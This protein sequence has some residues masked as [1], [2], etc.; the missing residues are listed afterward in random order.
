MNNHL[1]E[2]YEHHLKSGKFI[3]DEHQKKLVLKLNHLSQQLETSPSINIFRAKKFPLFSQGIY[4]W[5]KVGRGKT[6]LMDMFYQHVNIS[7]KKRIHFHAFMKT[8]HEALKILQGKKNPLNIIAKNL[9]KTVKLLCIDEFFVKDIA[10]AM[11]LSNLFQAL[12]NHEITI[13]LTSNTFPDDLYKNGLQKDQFN[14]TIALIKNNMEIISLDTEQDYRY[15]STASFQV[16]FNA[17]QTI[18][19]NTLFM[20]FVDDPH[21]ILYNTRLYLYDKAIEVKALSDN[22]IWFDFRKLCAI[23][24]SQNDY[25]NIAQKFKI[26]I[27]DNLNFIDENDLNTAAYFIKLIDI[28]YDSKNLLILSAAINFEQIYPKGKLS[29]EFQRTTSRLTEMQTES[30]IENTQEGILCK[31]RK[32]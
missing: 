23:P 29:V 16:F 26:V 27:I 18:E 2:Q 8:I 25:L 14:P 20:K 31:L 13:V 3:P 11:I 22:I 28:L 21:K 30:Y 12:F 17:D 19:L 4:I 9:K 5:G 24:R 10:D 32:V 6:W 15:R 1:I 7:Q